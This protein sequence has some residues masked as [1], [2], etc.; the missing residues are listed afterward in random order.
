MDAHHRQQVR[1]LMQETFFINLL[2]SMERAVREREGELK[3]T[4]R[5]WVYEARF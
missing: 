4:E 5:D 1:I 2:D 3:L